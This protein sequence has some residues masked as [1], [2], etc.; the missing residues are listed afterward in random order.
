MLRLDWRKNALNIEPSEAHI[1]CEQQKDIIYG[2]KKKKI[3]NEHLQTIPWMSRVISKL[4][5]SML[6]YQLSVG[7]LNIKRI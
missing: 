1:I 2:D 7:E 6:S 3:V 4:R 5:K